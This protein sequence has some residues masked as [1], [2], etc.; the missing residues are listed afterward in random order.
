MSFWVSIFNSRKRN[1][2]VNQEM[3]NE[4]LF[5]INLKNYLKIFLRE[6][7]LLKLTKD[8]YKD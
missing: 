3:K 5:T 4:E 6:K 1:H 7:A 2:N 8:T